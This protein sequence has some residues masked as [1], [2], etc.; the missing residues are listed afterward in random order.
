MPRTIS[1]NVKIA[2]IHLYERQ[3]LDLSDM[4]E[5]CGLSQRTWYRILKL[6]R[7]TG[8]VLPEAKSL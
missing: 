4:L 7:N 5:C 8:D 6:W 2:A 1:R 3:L